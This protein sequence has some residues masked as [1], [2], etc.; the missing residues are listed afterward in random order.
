MYQIKAEFLKKGAVFFEKLG[1]FCKKGVLSADV[2][3]PTFLC[4]LTAKPECKQAEV[5]KCC[6]FASFLHL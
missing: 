5:A 2:R 6:I 3:M 1:G 4:L